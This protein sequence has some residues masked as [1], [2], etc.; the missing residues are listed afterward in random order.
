MS[1]TKRYA[2]AT[3]TGE[4]IDLHFGHATQFYIFDTDGSK[5]TLIEKRDTPIFC[6][7]SDN[8]GTFDERIQNV[9]SLLSDCAGIISLRIGNPPAAALSLK[10]IDCYLIGDRVEDAVKAVYSGHIGKLI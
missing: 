9:I 1:D 6:D 7:G 5:V 3:K 8:C 10:G 2:C 4:L